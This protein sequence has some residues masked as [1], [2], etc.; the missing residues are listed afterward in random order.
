MTKEDKVLKNKECQC[1]NGCNC[2]CDCQSLILAGFKKGFGFWLA[3]LT[4]WIIISMVVALLY[5]FL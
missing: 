2:G 5:Y 1:G 4:I 3:G